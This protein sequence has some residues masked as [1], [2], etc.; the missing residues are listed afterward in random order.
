MKTPPWSALEFHYDFCHTDNYSNLKKLTVPVSIFGGSSDAYG[1][2]MVD[3]FA[4]Q[5]YTSAGDMQKLMKAILESSFRGDILDILF[6]QQCNNKLPALME[7]GV[8][9]AHKTGDLP[10]VEHDA[11][12]ICTDDREIIAIDL[13]TAQCALRGTD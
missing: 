9:F 5:I 10:G 11:G 6:R 4:S 1:L 3:A 7:G 2:E 8:R 13:P 12:I